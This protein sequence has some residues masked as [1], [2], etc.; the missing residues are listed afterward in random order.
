MTWSHKKPRLL[1][2]KDMNLKQD[3]YIFSPTIWIHWKGR[4]FEVET[5]LFSYF[6]CLRDAHLKHLLPCQGSDLLCVGGKKWKFLDDVLRGT[7][8]SL[9]QVCICACERVTR[10]DTPCFAIDPSLCVRVCTL[11]NC[12]FLPACTYLPTLPIHLVLP[13]L[14]FQDLNATIKYKS[15]IYTPHSMSDIISI[16]F[17]AFYKWAHWLHLCFLSPVHGAEL[18]PF[19]GSFK[20]WTFQFSDGEF[21]W[22]NW[23][24]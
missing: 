17:S 4:F 6:P 3:V 7:P 21:H 10:K 1:Q 8:A 18:G 5:K 2:Q 20:G 16:S 23:V 9:Y 14:I 13:F 12:V 11:V 19:S 22:C 24:L 15:E